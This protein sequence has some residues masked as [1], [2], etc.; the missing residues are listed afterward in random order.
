MKGG[1]VEG[2]QV[3]GGQVWEVGR[4]P[5]THAVSSTA[6]SGGSAAATTRPAPPTARAA[7][8][9]TAYPHSPHANPPPSPPAANPAAANA[10][11][12]GV[13]STPGM[14]AASATVDDA[15]TPSPPLTNPLSPASDFAPEPS[16]S[17]PADPPSPGSDSATTAAEP[18][19]D[20]ADRRRS[21][22][23]V[24][25]LPLATVDPPPAVGAILLAAIAMVGGTGHHVAQKS[26]AGIPH[27]AT[28]RELLVLERAS[29]ELPAGHSLSFSPPLSFPLPLSFPPPP[30][31][32]TLLDLRQL[33]ALLHPSLSLLSCLII[34]H[35]CPKLLPCLAPPPHT[36][37]IAASF[38]FET[39]LDL[40]QFAA[41]LRPSLP[42][43]LE[44]V[45]S[46]DKFVKAR[47][48]SLDRARLGFVRGAVDFC[49]ELLMLKLFVLPWLWERCALDYQL[50]YLW[51]INGRNEI[52]HSILFL[53]ASSLISQV[54]DLPFALYSTFVIEHRHGFNKQTLLGFIKDRILGILL[55]VVILPPVLAACI[56]IVQVGGNLVAVYLWLFMLAF[57]LFML[58]IYPVAIAPLFNKFTP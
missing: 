33:A 45:V 36:A 48:Y 8:P 25:L 6:D 19:A 35:N 11:I 15:P 4:S 32:A 22:T 40:R 7:L 12:P 39:L 27:V 37:F 18:S 14:R 34:P 31:F 47:A 38:A 2:G 3:G 42:P 41:L 56:R 53:F 43:A 26:L 13:D 51:G 21:A 46:H 23:A 30:P 44:G 50:P 55:M 28:A 5:T 29:N 57:S 54:V 49:V 9:A 1:Q 58:T 52:E 20:T 16:F 24:D 17:F 10:G